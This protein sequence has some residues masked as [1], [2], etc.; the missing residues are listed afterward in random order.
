MHLLKYSQ[1]AR[2]RAIY[3]LQLQR[4]ERLGSGKW[5]PTVELEQVERALELNKMTAAGQTG[6]HGL[7]YSRRKIP[8]SQQDKR[9][10][11]SS[12]MEDSFEE[13]RRLD[14]FR[15]E[16]QGDWTKWNN[17]MAQ[18][19][20]WKKIL[21]QQGSH[22]L[23]FYL[24][25]TTNTCATPDNL[26]R[27]GKAIDGQ[28]QV[29]HKRQATLGH[30]LNLCSPALQQGRYLWRHDS[31]LHEICSVLR[32]MVMRQCAVNKRKARKSPAVAETKNKQI[33]FVKAGTA[34]PRRS[35]STKPTENIFSRATDWKFQADLQY[36]EKGAKI[37]FRVPEEVIISPLAPDIII[38]SV[39]SKVV[40]FLELTVPWEE[41]TDAAQA[42]KDQKYT[43][44]ETLCQ[45][46]AWTVHRY[47]FEVG[48]R[49]FVAP[50]F[51]KAFT[52]IGM[53]SRQ[54]KELCRRVARKALV[55]SYILY[56]ERN[57]PAWTP[58]KPLVSLWDSRIDSLH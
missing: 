13:A 44:L 12:Q 21:Y 39:S 11:I 43:E 51:L 40:V 52:K 35:A 24:N 19:L 14:N 38:W 15:L 1:D 49:G 45:G 17:L 46:S 29:C 58:R 22:L 2:I 47:A 3:K 10:A 57:N 48:A 26:K 16:M 4:D 34:P 55:C 32:P 42:R 18:D 56:L 6:R 50:S 53:P 36:D 5:T 23:K 30:I 9:K 41:K 31:V 25:A 28:C 27:W 8:I 37:P 20:N 54:R 33:H 7:G